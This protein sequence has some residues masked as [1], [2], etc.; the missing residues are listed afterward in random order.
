[1]EQG[2]A[3]TS[4]LVIENVDID[5]TNVKGQAIKKVVHDLN[6]DLRAGE[7][8]ALVGESGSG[9]SVTSSSILGMLSK[10]LRM[11]GGRILVNGASIGSMSE[12]ELRSFRGRHIGYLFQNYQGS[13]TPFLTIGKQM[14]EII[15]RHTSTTAKKAKETAMGWLERV[16]LPAE[17]AFRS[18][19]FQL[20]GG[21]L[22]RASL[23]AA[24]MLK[25]SLIIADEPT[26][27]LDVVTG[28]HIL[29]LLREL[30]EE[31]G[32]AVLFIS[33]DLSHVFK[34]ADRMAV[35]Y[36]GHVIETGSTDCVSRAP[37]HPYT[38]LLMQAR[39]RLTNLSERLTTIPGEPGAVSRAGC[40]FAPR[41][42]YRT[43]RC[44]TVPSMNIIHHEHAVACH[45][46]LARG[47]P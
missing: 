44:L 25:P 45:E 7:M 17:R 43:D 10:P 35:M 22:Q 38:Q 20:S 19:P 11:T 15:R 21:Q 18:F 32:C 3:S 14:V 39:P 8:L 30:K 29:D 37:Q 41:C 16:R 40:C 2:S 9:K 12:K 5:V 24:L 1:M 6:L 27:A 4:V 36:A 33:H 47:E 28:E 46:R 13:F 34:R 26:T 31:T 42:P 23:A